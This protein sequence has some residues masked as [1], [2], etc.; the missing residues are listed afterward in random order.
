MTSTNVIISVTSFFAIF[1]FSL[2]F[3]LVII[4]VL[5]LRTARKKQA[6]IDRHQKELVAYLLDGDIEQVS[7][8]PSKSYHYSALEDFFSEYLMNYKVDSNKDPIK[9]F[10]EHFFLEEY[11]KR[12]TDRKWSVRMNTLYF[13]DLLKLEK[14]EADLLARLESSNV[15]HEEEYQ[16]YILLAS[17]EYEHL[18]ELFKKSKGL[19][20]F[21]LNIMLNR[22]VDD[23]NIDYYLDH[24]EELHQSWQLSILDLIRNKNLRSLKIV[25]FLENLISSETK[26]I[27]IRTLKTIANIGSVGSI[28]VIVNWYEENSQREDWHSSET[29]GERLMTARLM[30][31]IKNDKFIPVLEQ[32]ITDSK[33]N[34]RYEAAKAIRKYKNGKERLQEMA[35]NS[36]EA[37]TRN[38]AAEWVERSLD[39]E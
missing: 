12:L 36:P 31:M 24:F 20:P 18:Y 4:K 39:Y 22:L 13:F 29:N 30:G 8:V 34:V 3:Y 19:P 2:Y 10:V 9:K 38:I 6:W 26:E 33:Y 16:I 28:D 5:S 37:Y 35:T 17:L 1:L 15:T 21:L 7:F 32:L 14:V 25:S 23:G 27:R 11:R